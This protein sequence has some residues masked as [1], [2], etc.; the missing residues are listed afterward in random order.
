MSDAPASYGRWD[1]EACSGDMASSSWLIRMQLGGSDDSAS[2]TATLTR[3]P[4]LDIHQVRGVCSRV[5]RSAV[6][7]ARGDDLPKIRP[8]ANADRVRSGI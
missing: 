5:G 8:A 6:C 1:D 4:D 3:L 2:S 7:I